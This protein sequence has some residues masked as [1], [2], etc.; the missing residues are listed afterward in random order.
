MFR[1][2]ASI[3]LSD[4]DKKALIILLVV[5][6]ILVLILGL[7]GMAVRQ[8]MMYQAKRA[9]SMMHDVAVT[10]VIDSP[11]AFR[12]FGFKKNNRALFRDSLIPFLII[13]G[14]VLVW[15]LYN[16]FAKAWDHNIWDEFSDLFIRFK[17][18]NSEYPASD[19]LWVKVFGI[20][21]IARWPE[22]IEGYPRFE[23]THL[24]SY[25]IATA[26]IVAAIYYA[27]VCQAYISRAFMIYLRSNSV[28]EKSLKGFRASED[29]HVTPDKPIPPSD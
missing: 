20:T 13:L 29:I 9:D 27:V 2:F 16:V 19:P 28:Y 21:I 25:I 4:T 22:T 3:Q 26:T 18:D 10:H 12:R 17:L 8:T 5:L 1:L 11:K 6:V 15:A 7:I 24:A 23:I 14:A